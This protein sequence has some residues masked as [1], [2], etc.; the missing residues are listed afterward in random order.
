M[1]RRLPPVF[2]LML[3]VS[4]LLPAA[5]ARAQHLSVRPAAGASGGHGEAGQAG[6]TPGQAKSNGD[7]VAVT[8]S[9]GSTGYKRTPD[10]NVIKK[11]VG[12]MRDGMNR[13]DRAD[14][15]RQT[16]RVQNR[17]R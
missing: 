8:R 15:Q 17:R 11:L 2:L 14:K 7:K 6:P 12:Y 1:T 13:A 5:D 4:A 16:R 9:D 10:P 3:M